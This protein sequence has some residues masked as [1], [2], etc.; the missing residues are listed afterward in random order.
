MILWWLAYVPWYSKFVHHLGVI[1][2]FGAC[3]V[4]GHKGHV[5]DV[6]LL[7]RV[8]SEHQKPLLISPD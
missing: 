5:A 4:K 6:P 8:A 7:Y 3:S 1:I 2:Q